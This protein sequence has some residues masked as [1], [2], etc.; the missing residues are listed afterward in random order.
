MDFSIT[1]L[2][3]GDEIAVQQTAGVLAA[4]FPGHAE[5]SHLEAAL[6]EVIDSLA[7]PR[8]SRVAQSGNGTVLGWIGAVP[9][10]AGNVWE[11]HL[12]AVHPACRK[13]GIGRALVE[14][15]A[16]LARQRGGLTLWVGADDEDNR[17][18]LGGADLYPNPL[19]KL[20]AIHTRSQQHP[21]EFYQKLGFVLAGVLPDANGRGKPDFFWQNGYNHLTILQGRRFIQK[22]TGIRH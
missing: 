5:W 1:D 19:E 20:T 2:D 10:Y 16:G 9:L 14:D 18:S 22:Y 12:L 15:L 8:L 21:F 7:P 17:T 4:S 6:Q 11:I 3:P 13:R